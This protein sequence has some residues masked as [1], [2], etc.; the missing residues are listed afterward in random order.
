MTDTLNEIQQSLEGTTAT[1]VGGEATNSVPSRA[2]LDEMQWELMREGKRMLKWL[3]TEFMSKNHHYYLLSPL[4]HRM[5]A[6]GSE[7]AHWMLHLADILLTVGFGVL[8]VST[9]VLGI[10]TCL[11]AVEFDPDNCTIFRTKMKPVPA[12]GEEVE[13]H[14]DHQLLKEGA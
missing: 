1:H 6:Y 3:P 9:I 4:K 8:S 12:V 11:R 2:A 13:Q 7:P 14:E 5:D 10:Q